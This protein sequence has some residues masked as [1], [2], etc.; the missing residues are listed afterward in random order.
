[1]WNHVF[2][3]E[4]V[5]RPPA[6]ENELDR[7]V[8]AWNAALSE[9]EMAEIAGRQRNPFPAGH[10]LYDQYKPFDPALWKLPQKAFPASY[11]DFLRY[12]NGGEFQNGDRFFQF[13]GT[14]QLREYNLAYELPE[15]MKHAVSF[16]M[17]GC[18]N[19]YLF[20][21]REERNNNEYPILVAHSGYLD[22]DGC[23]LV[24]ESFLELCSGRTSMDEEMD[25][26]WV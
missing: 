7:F 23:V 4:H 6:D 5:K 25:R 12:S 1:M 26:R 18:G 9:Q 22:Y 17:D 8:T 11:L 2:E 19:H 13:F 24:A 14:D 3:L 15:Y 20:D 10:E 21:M 16:A